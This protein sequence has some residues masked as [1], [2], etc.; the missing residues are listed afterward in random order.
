MTTELSAN[1][2][3]YVSGTS[4]PACSSFSSTYKLSDGGKISSNYCYQTVTKTGSQNDPAMQTGCVAR[5]LSACTPGSCSYKDYYN[6]TDGS[7]TPTN[8]TKGQTCTSASADYYLDSGVAKQCSAYNATYPDS[9]GGNIDYKYCYKTV[10]KTGSQNACSQPANSASY[11]CGTCN[12]GSCTYKDYNGATD[13]SCTPTDCTKPVATVSCKA[14]FYASGVTC[15]ACPT[16]YPYSDAGTTSDGYCFVTKTNTGSQNACSQPANSASYTCGTCTPGTCNWRDYKSATDT[17]CTPTNCDKPVASVTC[18]TG[19]YTSGVTCPACTNKPD[20]SAYTGTAT[21]D[22]CPWECDTGYGQT[23]ANLCAQM[24]T[25]GFQ[26]LKSSTGVSIPLYT[27]AQTTH[28]I[29]V[30]SQSGAMC[31]ASLAS[32]VASGAINVNLGGTTYHAIY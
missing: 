20:N 30:K 13:G 4:C 25:A 2:N 10:T 29:V 32:G 22:A 1:A 11:T 5:T 3:Y 31:Y 8:C 19:F 28:S 15:P 16:A 17:T 27:S 14:N 6:A 7:C 26:H 9:D 21:S 24:C 12:P 18:N 23:S